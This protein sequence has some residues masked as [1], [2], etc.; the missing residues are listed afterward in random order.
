MLEVLLGIFAA[1]PYS[2][3][4]LMIVNLLFVV[5]LVVRG[6]QGGNRTALIIGCLFSC[7]VCVSCIAARLF[8]LPFEFG[9][10]E[11][12]QIAFSMQYVL[13][14]F[15][16]NVDYAKILVWLVRGA[17]VFSAAIVIAFFSTGTWHNMGG[18]FPA[19]RLWGL[20]FFPGWPN[21]LS[22]PLGF[23]LWAILLKGVGP[24]RRHL[25]AFLISFA[26]Y[27]TT[28]R[29]AVLACALVWL[30][31]LYSLP[32][33]RR[34]PAFTKALFVVFLVA[35][36][37]LFAVTY[38]SDDTLYALTKSYDRESITNT[39]LQLIELS[40][41]FGYGGQTLEQV[42]TLMPVSL[43]AWSA[44]QTHNAILEIAIRH[45]VP[46]CILLVAFFAALFSRMKGRDRWALF[47]ILFILSLTQDFIRNFEFLF[48]W[49]LLI[50]F[51][52]SA[53]SR[54]ASASGRHSKE[55]GKWT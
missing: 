19:E 28:S 40:P 17:L 41:V 43:G 25:A 35:A 30:Y 10:R 1:I 11:L 55:D 29:G 49:H 12:V 23:A 5:A 15:R 9:F 24:K 42:Q 21:G 50:H 4:S 8:V 32:F 47:A 52:E 14:A 18:F 46:G 33:W 27:V 16:L 34:F 3:E 26:M 7:W 45:G 39:S 6:A 44:Q 13:L 54:K 37:V 53:C 22:V 51:P 31:Y 36:A 20:P 48:C 2:V 38:L